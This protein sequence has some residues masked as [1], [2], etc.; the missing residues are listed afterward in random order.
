MDIRQLQNFLAV[1]DAGSVVDAAR[2]V[3]RSQPALSLSIQRLEKAVGT[4]LFERST[5]GMVPNAFG[6][7]LLKR[8]RVITAQIGRAEHD[9][10]DL[11]TLQSGRIV[12]GATALVVHSV[13][14]RAIIRLHETSPG[15][16]VTILEGQHDRMM[17]W[18]KSGEVDFAAMAITPE[19][20]S[21][22]DL[23]HIVYFPRRRVTLAA[24]ATN[25]I[26]NRLN[27]SARDLLSCQWLLPIRTDFFRATVEAVFTR[28]GLPLPYSATEFA[29]TSTAKRLVIE[30]PYVSFF[31]VMLIREELDRNVMKEIRVPEFSWQIERPTGAIFRRDPPLTPGARKLLEIAGQVACEVVP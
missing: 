1:A 21:D 6:R 27:L 22:P 15:V 24:S 19:V 26:L 2:R 17:A 11:L 18:A 20:L 10:Q 23:E 16:A 8:A 5:E 14:P 28:H 13:L 29:S 4:P 3:G 30:G 12:V 9:I 25:P 7:A 31:S